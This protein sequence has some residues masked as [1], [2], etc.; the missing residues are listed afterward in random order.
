MCAEEELAAAEAARVIDAAQRDSHAAAE[1]QTEKKRKLIM[2][3]AKKRL[4][5]EVIGRIE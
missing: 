3:S 5:S 1:G 2:R 4:R